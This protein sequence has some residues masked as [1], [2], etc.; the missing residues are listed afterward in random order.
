MMWYEL[1]GSDVVPPSFNSKKPTHILRIVYEL[2]AVF[3]FEGKRNSEIV[4]IE[5]ELIVNCSFHFLLEYGYLL[6]TYVVEMLS[7]AYG[8]NENN[9]GR[10]HG[11]QRSELRCEILLSSDIE[12]LHLLREEVALTQ[13]FCKLILRLFCFLS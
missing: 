12:P 1:L 8:V 5:V 2:F 9:R 4:L 13:K 6:T 7:L 10:N 11:H 3:S